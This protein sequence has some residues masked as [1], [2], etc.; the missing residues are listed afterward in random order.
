[1]LLPAVLESLQLYANLKVVSMLAS[2]QSNSG[3]TS[4]TIH[5]PRTWQYWGRYIYALHS[6]GRSVVVGQCPLLHVNGIRYSDP[7][8]DIYSDPGIQ[9]LI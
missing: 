2:A 9:T 6:E 8:S 1:M 3:L 4:G 7:D 5:R